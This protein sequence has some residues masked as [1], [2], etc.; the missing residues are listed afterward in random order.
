MLVHLT[1]DKLYRI[2]LKAPFARAIRARF[3]VPALPLMRG[4]TRWRGTPYTCLQRLRL[5]ALVKEL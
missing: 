5:G 3:L 4:T 2:L 1:I